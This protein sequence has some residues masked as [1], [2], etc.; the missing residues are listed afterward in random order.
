MPLAPNALLQTNAAVATRA[1]SASQ[2]SKAVDASKDNASSFSDVYSKQAKAKP[3]VEHDAPTKTVRDKPAPDKSKAVAAKDKPD[4][5]DKAAADK[6]TVAD[7]GNTLPA[8][9]VASSDQDQ[10]PGKDDASDAPVVDPSL[11]TTVT[12]DPAPVVDPTQDPTLLALAAQASVQPPAAPVVAAPKVDTPVTAPAVAALATSQATT[13]APTTQVTP[14]TGEKPFDPYADPLEGLSAVQ[15]ALENAGS[16]VQT[17]NQNALATAATGKSTKA[18]PDTGSLDPS[19]NIANN[20]A[21]LVDQM[22]V[23][24]TGTESNDKS[25]GG[26]IDDGLKDAQTA[27]T[28]TRVDNFADR[29]AAMSQAAQQAKVPAAATPVPLINQPLAM[30]QSGWSEGIVD[31]VMYLSSQNLKSADIKLEPAELGRLDIRVNMAQDQQTQ[32]TFMSAHVGVREALESQMGKLRDSFAQQGLGQ[33][34]VSVADQ[35]RQQSQQQQA[36]EQAQNAQ[37]SGSGNGTGSAGSGDASLDGSTVADA[38]IPI[39]QPATRVIGSS[40]VDYYA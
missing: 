33:V 39:S 15:L 10:D 21:A 1:A 26:L 27:A 11:L 29:L 22:P 34:D 23:E 12:P 5:D 17:M 25:F 20:L 9:P 16:K 18:S 7:S 4:T 30:H 31:R 3:A 38:A 32:V 13:P 37:R 8:T 36:Q 24:K 6:S 28:D 35:S 14:P 2:S 40:E 19:Q